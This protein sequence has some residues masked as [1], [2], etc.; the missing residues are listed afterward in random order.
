PRF[1]SPV[2]EGAQE[3]PPLGEALDAVVERVGHQHRPSRDRDPGRRGPETK[4]AVAGAAGPEL[5]PPLAGPSERVHVHEGGAGRRRGDQQDGEGED[6][7]PRHRRRRTR[8]WVLRRD[9]PPW[10]CWTIVIRTLTR[11]RV[12]VRRRP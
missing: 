10:S 1:D 9:V 4:A 11:A 6:E 7:A 8:F 3:S 5:A 12:R 2:A